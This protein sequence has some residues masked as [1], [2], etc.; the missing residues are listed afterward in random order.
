MI[1]ATSEKGFFAAHW[2]WLIAILAIAGLAAA[3][4]FLVIELGNDPDALADDMRAELAGPKRAETGVE[5]VNLDLY[6]VAAKE[7]RSPTR[8]SEPAETLASFLASE[9]RIYCEQGDD[10][11]HKSCGRPMPADLKVCPFC[12]TKQPEEKK[13]SLDSDG[14]GLPDDWET[15]L[16]LNPNDPADADADL[17]E[18][19]F[20]NM[21]EYLAKTDPKDPTS[22]PDYL[23][24]LSVAPQLMTKVI[25]FYLEKATPL[26][27]GWRLY[28]KDP[29]KRND[30]G[31]MGLS[32]SVVKGEAIGDTGYV[33]GDYEQKFAD[34]SIKGGTGMKKKVDVSEVEIT[35]K[36]DGRV[37][38]LTVGVKNTPIEVEATLVYNRRGTQQFTVAKGSEIELNGSKYKVKEIKDKNESPSK[39]VRVVLTDLAGGRE[40]AI[41][42]LE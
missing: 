42:A 38:R 33:A 31:K 11:E 37:V 20:S 3:A 24:S 10:P 17:D 36:A 14:D 5:K 7:T 32:Y 16:G 29:K 13:V 18:D 28:F 19:G 25:P 40:R 26:R 8:V 23:D 21:E 27:G 35:R 12:K 30:Y 4:V 34:K 1:S 6:Y 15:S 39:R 2:D 41:D 22:H 9:R